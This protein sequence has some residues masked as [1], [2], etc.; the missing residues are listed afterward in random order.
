MGCQV[1]ADPGI[2]YDPLVML[3]VMLPYLPWAISRAGFNEPM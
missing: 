2:A 1:H 3:K